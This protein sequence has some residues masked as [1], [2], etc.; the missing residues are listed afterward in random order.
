MSYYDDRD[1]SR[2]PPPQPSSS[3]YGGSG[4]NGSSSRSGYPQQQQQQ[5][6]M[7]Q[8]APPAA[9]ATYQRSRSQSR[10]PPPPAAATGGRGGGGYSDGGYPDS[11]AQQYPPASSGYSSSRNG[12]GSRGGRDDYGSPAPPSLSYGPPSSTVS[13]GAGGGGRDRMAEL[14]AAGVQR[15]V[16]QFAPPSGGG[17]GAGAGGAG[18]VTAL[19]DDIAALDKTLR[20][21]KDD[22]QYIS[23]CQRRSFDAVPEAQAAENKRELEAVTSQTKSALQRIRRD[24]DALDGEHSRLRKGTADYVMCANQLTNLKK[25]YQAAVQEFHQLETDFGNA[26]RDRMLREMR[27]VTPDATE[28][29]LDEYLASGGHGGIFAQQ[30]LQSSRYGNA[31]RVLQQV[32][33][34]QVEL[35]LIERTV[36]ELAQLFL[37]LNTL[38]EQQDYTINQVVEYVEEAAVNIERGEKEVEQAIETRKDSI[39][40]SWY[41]LIFL[42][43]VIIAVVLWFFWPSILK[44]ISGDKK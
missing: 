31:R 3:R 22:L 10:G 12:G 38:I 18:D 5:Q 8:Y 2:G 15:P 9:T 44:A 41:F 37:D 14:R 20:R 27:I 13:S 26:Q 11:G 39:K 7:R 32:E 42:I 33:D 28:Q 23:Q 43:I 35:E 34:R 1:R 29:D 16:T 24:L 4:G 17:T 30:V 25:N 19:L 6:P 21:V 40:W 36:S